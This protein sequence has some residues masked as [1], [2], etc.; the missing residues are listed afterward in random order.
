MLDVDRLS[1]GEASKL[2]GRLAFLNS[3]VFNRLGRA[4]IRPIIWRQLQMYGSSKL[5]A[6]LKW[7][8][9][10]F[11]TVLKTKL[12]R[13]VPFLQPLP[14]KRVVLYSDATSDGTVAAVA[15]VQGKAMYTCGKLPARVRRLLKTRKTNI[16]AFELLAAVA[17]ILALCPQQLHDAAIVHF[18]DSKPAL[19]CILKGFSKQRDLSSIT[20]RL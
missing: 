11:M 15:I 13:A 14:E 10:W 8:I 19:S 12:V 3:L 2:S 20:G 18:I 1:P 16:V 9:T 4:L 6:R 17:A 7:A 5:T